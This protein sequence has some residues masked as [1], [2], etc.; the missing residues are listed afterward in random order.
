MIAFISESHPVQ[1]WHVVFGSRR[2][3]S[4]GKTPEDSPDLYVSPGY[5]YSETTS[6]IVYGKNGM[7]LAQTAFYALAASHGKYLCRVQAWGEVDKRGD[8]CAARHREVLWMVDLTKISLEWVL[9][10]INTYKNQSGET[11]L[12]VLR[13]NSDSANSLSRYTITPYFLALVDIATKVVNGK[14][15]IEELHKSDGWISPIFPEEAV[16]F[17]LTGQTPTEVVWEAIRELD[18]FISKKD[19][20]GEEDSYPRHWELRT[21][22]SKDFEKF[23]MKAPRVTD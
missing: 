19:K 18:R 8:V 16:V 11:V 7:H 3:C 10:A 20:D 9:L 1:G 2:L 14:S 21:R 5:V 6:P 12:D 17:S 22:L 23:I 15:S 4:F 13:K